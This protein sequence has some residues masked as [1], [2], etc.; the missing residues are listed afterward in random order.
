[1]RRK[2]KMW[3]RELIKIGLVMSPAVDRLHAEKMRG[4]HS[5][6]KRMLLIIAVWLWQRL[7]SGIESRACCHAGREAA[8]L[9][10]V[11]A[12]ALH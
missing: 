3:G 4:S 8:E 2:E 6:S 12:I 10:L 7:C 5:S 11:E 1:M 9:E